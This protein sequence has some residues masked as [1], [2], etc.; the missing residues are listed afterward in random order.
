MSLSSFFSRKSIRTIIEHIPLLKRLSSRRIDKTDEYIRFHCGEAAIKN[1]TVHEKQLWVKFFPI[2][3]KFKI[4]TIV[5]VGAHT[6]DIALALNRIFPGRRFYLIEPVPETFQILNKNTENYKNIHC[7]NIALGAEE[8]LFEM[9]V[10][11]FSA[12]SS[13]LPSNELALKEF[14]QLGKQ[15]A[16]KV[17]V[18]TLDNILHIYGINTVDL[19]I[20]DVQGYEDKVFEGS[21]E[22]LKNCKVV[23]SELSLWPLYT[24]SSTFD[25]VYQ[26]LRK[27]GFQMRYI[28]NTIAGES[29]Q[30]LQIDGVF[31]RE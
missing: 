30:I 26:K 7:I 16:I 9:F 18:K 15:V 20:I 14:P 28:I 2:F 24:G 8:G 1:W 4:D 3:D 10:D 27:L 31:S 19:L 21:S 12:A 5:Y 22:T 13:L 25:S 6:G 23:V 17:R 11:Q 29:Q